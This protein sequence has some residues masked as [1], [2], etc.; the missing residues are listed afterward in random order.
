MG[1]RGGNGEPGKEAKQRETLD[2]SMESGV[3]ELMEAEL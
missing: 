2:Y 3:R 1:G